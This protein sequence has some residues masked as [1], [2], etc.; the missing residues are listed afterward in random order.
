MGYSKIYTMDVRELYGSITELVNFLYKRG[1]ARRHNIATINYILWG[2]CVQTA[3]VKENPEC[4]SMG[5]FS[6]IGYL[7]T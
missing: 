4:A 3:E 1:S 2:G 5:N 6:A 7:H